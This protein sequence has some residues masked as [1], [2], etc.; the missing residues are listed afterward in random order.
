[1]AGRRIVVT[2][3]SSHWAGELARRLERDPRVELVA[4]IDTDPPAAE[5]ERTEFI[6]ADIRS[7]VLSRLLPA[8][9]PDTVVHCGFLWY[10][11]P[12]KPDRAL[13]EINVIGVLQLLAAC[14]KTPSLTG[15]VVRGSAAIYG[16][17]GAAPF[18]F[19]EDMARRY[20]LKTRFQRDVGELERYFDNFARR[21]P[22]VSCCMLRYQPEIGPDIDTPLVGYL[23]L[24]L[25]PTQLGFDPRLQFVHSSDATGAL[26]AAVRNP[27]RGA[28]N[29]APSGAVS[30]SR[31][32][33][34]AGKPTLPIPHPLFGPALTQLGRQ[35]RMGGTYNDGVRLLRFG[36]GV[37]N[38]RLREDIGYEPEFDAVGAVRD[39]VDKSKG[40]RLVGV[41][42]PRTLADAVAR[43]S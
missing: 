16:S 18:F 12:G 37:D 23:S 29:V 8:L 38:R 28:V 39:F 20:P 1:M 5:L 30:L 15:V 33:R 31:I 25:V 40:R 36:R 34:M 32:L 3:I 24:S 10:P 19:T 7:P 4:G 13:H 14:E 27:V 11:A 41:P 26:E 22:A 6:E 21:R 9:E 2:G 42:G 43:R 35:L 17:E